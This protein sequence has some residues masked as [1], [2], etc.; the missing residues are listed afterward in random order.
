MLPLLAPFL[1]A[2]VTVTLA[3]EA[4]VRGTELSLTAL[5]LVEG[6][7][8]AEVARASALRLGYAPA[9]GYSRLL[10]ADRLREELARLAPDLEIE[11]RGA[12][13]CRVWPETEQVGGEAVE[14]AARAEL[15]RVLG[16]RDASFRLRQPAAPLVVPA[17]ERPHEVLSILEPGALRSGA[18][19]IPVRV[20]VDGSLYRTVWTSWEVELWETRAVL[21]RALRAGEALAGDMLENKRMLVTARSAADPRAF[22]AAAVSGA[23]AARDLAA[24]EPLHEGDLV[25]P[26]LVQRGDTLFLEIKKG[27]IRARVPAAAQEEGAAGDTIRVALLEGEREMQAVVVARDLVRIDLAPPR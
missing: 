6:A 15:Q 2:G 24:G 8:A 17:G 18:L 9:P 5:A 20:L 22:D 14:A 12:S 19:S 1:V 4:R 3:P 16:A 23:I 11:L 10:A 13:A 7:D 21:K 26:K 25:R 27:A